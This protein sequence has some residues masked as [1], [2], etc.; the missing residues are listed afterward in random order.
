MA[1]VK[2]K[3]TTQATPG[4]STENFKRVKKGFLQQIGRM[5]K[6]RNFPDSLII[7]LDQT[8]I[9]FIPIGDWTMAAEGSRRE[10]VA[11]LG[12]VD[13]GS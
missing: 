11:V 8:G 1:Y 2:H 4:M 3:A 13:Y 12:D 6:L 7:N 10:E 5:V 9:K